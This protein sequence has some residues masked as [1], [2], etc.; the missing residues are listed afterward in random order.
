MY[1]EDVDRILNNIVSNIVK[2]ADAG[3]P[4]RIRSVSQDGYAAV[5]YTHLTL[6]TI[7]SV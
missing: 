6:P 1:S 5:S 3:E 2:Y 4:V 7:C